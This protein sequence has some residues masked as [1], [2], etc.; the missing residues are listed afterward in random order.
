[1]GVCLHI[2]IWKYGTGLM[3]L[4]YEKNR[5]GL[6]HIPTDIP[7]NTTHLYLVGN[8]ISQINLSMGYLPFLIYFDASDNSLE[9]ISLATFT[10]CV[11][12]P[13][14]SGYGW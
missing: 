5:N 1:M 12:I 10:G 7:V 13:R 11:C 2:P 6:M 3:N 14:G 9:T 4:Q 8:S